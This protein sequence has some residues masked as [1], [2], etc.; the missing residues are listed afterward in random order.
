MSERKFISII[1]ICTEQPYR[2]STRQL[3]AK[4]ELKEREVNWLAKKL[5]LEIHGRQ[6]KNLR[7]EIESFLKNNL[8]LTAV[9]AADG[10]E[11]SRYLV[12]SVARSIGYRFETKHSLKNI[13]DRGIN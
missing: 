13:G 2:F 1:N 10:T 7:C 4:F 12:Y 11:S 3:A 5:C 8:G 6:M 9:D